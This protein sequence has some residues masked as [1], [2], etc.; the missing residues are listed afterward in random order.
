MSEAING[1]VVHPITGEKVNI[2]ANK[3]V[4]KDQ[5]TGIINGS[6]LVFDEPTMWPAN[7]ELVGLM[8]CD[9]CGHRT[10][11]DDQKE[12]CLIKGI[13]LCQPH[14]APCKK[15]RS[16][17]DEETRLQLEA[18]EKAREQKII[19]EAIEL[20]TSDNDVI[21]ARVIDHILLEK[22]INILSVG[23]GNK[24]GEITLF[25]HDG[26]RYKRANSDGIEN[27]MIDFFS[28]MDE[29]LTAT[30]ENIMEPVIN[31]DKENPEYIKAVN[32]ASPYVSK[33]KTIGRALNKNKR[34]SI[35]ATLLTMK[36]IEKEKAKLD[37]DFMFINE[38]TGVY[39][40]LNYK[41]IPHDSEQRF[42]MLA[43]F[44]Y[45]PYASCPMFDANLEYMLPNKETRDCFMEIIASYY[46]G[47]GVKN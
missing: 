25:I 31:L 35:E 11:Q 4:I 14:N 47:A 16:Q 37:A 19:D 20:G 29:K 30:I 34:H 38:Q 24:K 3:L 8:T 13:E 9:N 46:S 7:D 32:Q 26:K 17:T 43:G 10:I 1:P 2:K 45:D 18:I 23:M 36:I 41:E 6:G 42:S 5:N 44:E 12:Y 40:L 33:K 28:K 39:D 21:L 27:Y 15:H 22:N